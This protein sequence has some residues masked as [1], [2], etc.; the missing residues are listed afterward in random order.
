MAATNL[1]MYTMVVDMNCC[2][3]LLICITFHIPHN[4]TFC[5]F[6]KT[7]ASNEATFTININSITPDMVFNI[8]TKS[9]RT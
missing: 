9:A 3:Y 2:I 1:N 8:L 6:N 7:P 5:I 4:F